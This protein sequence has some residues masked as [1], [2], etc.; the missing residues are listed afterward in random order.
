MPR[1]DV[2]RL[3]IDANLEFCAVCDGKLQSDGV[4]LE[5]DQN[6]LLEGVGVVSGPGPARP[7]HRN[8]LI[9]G[10]RDGGGG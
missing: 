1:V 4:A 9:A 5:C 2:D 3:S 6:G 10:D 7:G 8:R